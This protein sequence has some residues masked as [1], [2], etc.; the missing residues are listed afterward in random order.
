MRMFIAAAMS[1]MLCMPG[2]TENAH[3]S[4]G[5]IATREGAPPYRQR[6]KFA[7][8]GVRQLRAAASNIVNEMAV[9]GNVR[10]GDSRPTNIVASRTLDDNVK[11]G[12]VE[13]SNILRFEQSAPKDLR[14]VSEEV[15]DASAPSTA[16]GESGF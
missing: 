8:T 6:V 13:R 4:G 14:R 1:L 12:L 7:G 3:G 16:V 11:S 9:P 2:R 15:A 10:D 5:A